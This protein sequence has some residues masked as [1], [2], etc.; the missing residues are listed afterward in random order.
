VIAAALK[1]TGSGWFG[2]CLSP[3]ATGSASL[4][5]MLPG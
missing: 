2:A 5:G 4:A 3:A 1:I